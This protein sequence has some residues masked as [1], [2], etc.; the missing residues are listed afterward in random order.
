M[1]DRNLAYELMVAVGIFGVR[2]ERSKIDFLSYPISMDLLE[3]AQGNL[4]KK[5]K[6]VPPRQGPLIPSGPAWAY[7]A[8]RSVLSSSCKRL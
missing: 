1:L 4:M 8:I 7:I 3:R 5:S 2:S 6:T